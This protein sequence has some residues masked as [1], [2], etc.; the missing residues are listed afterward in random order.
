M[1]RC[2]YLLLL[3]LIFGFL[4][5]LFRVEAAQRAKERQQ[6][7]FMAEWT[8]RAVTVSE[9]P[10]TPP[11]PWVCPDTYDWS[12]ALEVLGGMVDRLLYEWKIREV[13]DLVC[14]G[15]PEALT[16]RFRFWGPSEASYWKPL[17][18]KAVRTARQRTHASWEKNAFQWIDQYLSKL[19][20]E[21]VA[22]REDLLRRKAEG[23]KQLRAQRFMLEPVG[24][25]RIHAAPTPPDVR[26]DWIW[27]VVRISLLGILLLLLWGTLFLRSLRR[28][29]AFA[30]GLAVCIAL[31]GRAGIGWAHTRP[32]RWVASQPLALR[33]GTVGPWAWGE[34]ILYQKDKSPDL[35]IVCVE[36]AATEEEALATLQ[37]RVKAL[38]ARG[39]AVAA[40]AQER[41]CAAPTKALAEAEA[42]GADASRLE[43]LRRALR[44][45][46]GE[47]DKLRIVLYPLTQP[48]ASPRTVFVK[49]A[50]VGGLVGGICWVIAV[51]LMTRKR[52]GN[53]KPPRLD[54]PTAPRDLP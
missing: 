28:G 50:L 33:D 20:A 27:R 17:L 53:P 52:R 4:G 15:S 10:D 3:L 8:F 18:L 29:L 34:G 49:E 48:V 31:G 38:K 13:E 21:D 19:P 39:D 47:A 46:E 25:L 54:E 7:P 32:P 43:A 22:V 14:S 9:D 37:C 30:F 24:D 40:K 16:L 35:L 12:E 41:L 51:G 26:A 5:Y 42:E 23:R 45:A 2:A 6:G 11:Q 36:D 44:K 1:K